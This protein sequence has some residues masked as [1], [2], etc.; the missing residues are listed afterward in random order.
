MHISAVSRS[1]LLKVWNRHKLS[2]WTFFFEGVHCCPPESLRIKLCHFFFIA[3]D[4][5]HCL[6][7]LKMFHDLVSKP[8]H[9][10]KPC[11]KSYA[12]VFVGRVPQKVNV[13]KD[14]RNNVYRCTYCWSCFLA[15]WWN[16]D[17][18]NNECA[19]CTSN[20]LKG[21]KRKWIFAS[22]VDMVHTWL[23]FFN[24]Q[25]EIYT[26]QTVYMSV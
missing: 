13:L 18:E 21:W 5:N 8:K 23:C 15:N 9:S 17:W 3:T 2:V 20:I 7:L 14:Y 24:L 1:A 25:I 16:L 6:Q 22:F 19:I 11:V 10:S 12:Y 4:C 26:V